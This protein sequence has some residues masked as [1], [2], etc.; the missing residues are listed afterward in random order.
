MILQH[1]Q[2]SE[3]LCYYSDVASL[4]YCSND[5]ECSQNTCYALTAVPHH[6][7]TQHTASASVEEHRDTTCSGEYDEPRVLLRTNNADNHYYI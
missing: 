1:Y 6:N 5:I 7:S 2:Q 4:I 3:R